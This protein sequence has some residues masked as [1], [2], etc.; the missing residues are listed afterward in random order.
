[1][2]SHPRMQPGPRLSCWYRSVSSSS[3]AA[4]SARGPPPAAAGRGA[5]ALSAAHTAGTASRVCRHSS[6]VWSSAGLA[7]RPVRAQCTPAAVVIC[8]GW[9]G[10]G[11]PEALE[12]RARLS[13]LG[14]GS[15]A[16]VPAGPG[17]CPK[18]TTAHAS[19]Q[20]AHLEELAPSPLQ[21]FA[22]EP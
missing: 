14:T 1:M 19:Q 15:Q 17:R 12:R 9:G 21:Q 6:T 10:A 11:L 18:G 13:E 20:P 4:V 2:S 8:E 22:H 3:C 5:C 16:A 7:A